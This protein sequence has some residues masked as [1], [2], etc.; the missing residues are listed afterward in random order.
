LLRGPG[1]APT[2]GRYRCWSS[3]LVMLSGRLCRP[4]GGTGP[5]THSYHHGRMGPTPIH[6]RR[7][8]TMRN[9]SLR[10]VGRLPVHPQSTIHGRYGPPQVIGRARH[11]HAKR[12]LA[13]RVIVTVFRPLTPCREIGIALV[14]RHPR[15]RMLNDDFAVP[16]GAETEWRSC[17][18]AGNCSGSTCRSRA[19]QALGFAASEGV[20][21]PTASP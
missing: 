13:V 21:C 14:L 20:T 9:A 7:N 1:C 18:A 17:S 19:L 15:P 3:A 5:H 16:P 2:E 12:K 10:F 11:N 8:K 6:G 4:P